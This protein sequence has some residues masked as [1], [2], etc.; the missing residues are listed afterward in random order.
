MNRYIA[1]SYLFALMFQCDLL[2]TAVGRV[3]AIS[4][5]GC[6]CNITPVKN[7]TAVVTVSYFQSSVFTEKKSD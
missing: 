2:L 7:S 1:L 4:F 5:D 3:E 6:K